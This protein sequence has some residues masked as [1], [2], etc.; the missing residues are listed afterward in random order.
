MSQ[1]TDASAPTRVTVLV[2]D[3]EPEVLAWMS[4]GLS[5]LKGITIAEAATV[6]EAK[7]KLKTLRP[8]LL[9]SDLRLPDGSG[10]E[11]IGTV[12]SLQL[13]A[14][15][16]F[17]SG[18][19]GVFRAMI[20]RR[21][22]IEVFEK[23]L[24]LGALIEAVR[25]R[26]ELAADEPHHLPFSAP[27]YIQLACIG[28]HSVCVNIDQESRELG[29]IIVYRGEIWAAQDDQGKGLLAFE[30]LLLRS[31]DRGKVRAHCRNLTGAPGP[32][33][34]EGPWQG[35]LLEAARRWDERGL[36]QTGNLPDLDFEMG[37]AV[38]GDPPDCDPEWDLDD[39]PGNLPLAMPAEPRPTLATDATSF[40]DLRET[41]LSALLKKDYSRAYVALV[42]ANRLQP[43]DTLIR[44]NL[45]RLKTLGYGE[46]D[47]PGSEP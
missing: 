24:P 26:L 30:R 2:V 39:A 44:A 11:L 5:R 14:P 1:L 29:Q 35:L 15:I 8:R 45:L 23:P 13:H 40:E 6:A 25:H 36:P 19:V 4:Q 34:V 7:H 38:L 46:P 12:E 27:D 10:V 42:T 9:V 18:Y 33:T 37:A 16:L 41:A 31:L 43:Q 32:R 28:Q 17:L 21:S 3:D 22:D 47:G 20:P